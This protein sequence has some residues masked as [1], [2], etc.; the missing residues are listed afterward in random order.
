M[1][2]RV[3]SLQRHYI[4]SFMHRSMTN[5]LKSFVEFAPAVHYMH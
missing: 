3:V 1:V 4:F 5:A 2:E